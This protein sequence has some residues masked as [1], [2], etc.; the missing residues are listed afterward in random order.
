MKYTYIVQAGQFSHEFQ[1]PDKGCHHKLGD[2][3]EDDNDSEQTV[4]EIDTEN[5]FVI[6]SGTINE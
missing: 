3:F 1:Y 6:C 5:G 2:V 4:V